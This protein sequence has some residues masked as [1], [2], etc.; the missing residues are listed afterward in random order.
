MTVG[1][2]QNNIAQ[3][4]I[5]KSNATVLKRKI[6]KKSSDEMTPND[7]LLYS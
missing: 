7:I 4:P 1:I 6:L 2:R 3:R 5:V